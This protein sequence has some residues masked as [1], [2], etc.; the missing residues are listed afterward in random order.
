MRADNKL[1]FGTEKV[2]SLNNTSGVRSYS[3]LST[4]TLGFSDEL[5]KALRDFRQFQH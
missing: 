1:F 4:R 3:A 5:E 2:R